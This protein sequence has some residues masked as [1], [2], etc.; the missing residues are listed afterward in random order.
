M[1]K[2]IIGIHGL[3]NKPPADLLEKWWI[4]SIEEGLEKSAHKKINYDFKLVYWA[5][6]LHA[7][8][9]DPAIFDKEN[10]FY[11]A[12]PYIPS[13]NQPLPQ[14]EKSLAS[15]ILNYLEE[16]LDNI[17]LKE[18]MTLNF[19]SVT[20]RIIHKYFE[21]L[22][23]YY[24]N[25]CT[26]WDDPKCMARPAICNRL[27]K[28]LQKHKD[29]E[30]MLIAHSMGSIIAYD[31]LINHLQELKVD[32]FISV[33]SP[34]GLPIITSRI[35]S[36]QK[37]KLKQNQLAAPENILKKWINISDPE[38]LVAMDHTLK[39]DFKPNKKGIQAQDL[40]VYNDYIVDNKRNPHKIYGYLRCS[41]MT[42]IIKEFSKDE[43]KHY[44][45][46]TFYRLKKMLQ[47]KIGLKKKF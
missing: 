43:K 8:P 7:K 17:F 44:F 10:I 12:E 29:D 18:D 4:T 47:S 2:I 42:E 24:S 27:L 35:F 26:T 3:G 9:E 36:E 46:D 13:K 1:A 30:I 33:G 25:N 37:D 19:S 20:D 15:K 39:D 14:V 22:E 28:V 5:D 34:L 11:I 6:I 41:E 16:Q 40:T 23:I 21:D 32:T 38:D 31:V 45:W